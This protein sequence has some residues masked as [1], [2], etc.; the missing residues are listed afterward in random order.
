MNSP[1]TKNH[2]WLHH[3]PA[4]SLVEDG[5]EYALLLNFLEEFLVLRL[6][7]VGPGSKWIFSDAVLSQKF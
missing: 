6:I 2:L 3:H 5:M 4:L 7:P 1:E